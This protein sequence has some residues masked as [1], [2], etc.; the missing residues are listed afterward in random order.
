ME[1]ELTR[2][3]IQGLDI[4]TGRMRVSVI[5]YQVR[6]Y[7]TCHN[8]AISTINIPKSGNFVLRSSLERPNFGTHSINTVALSV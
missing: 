3:I 1:Q 2:M 4:D 7:F 5:T 8:S 6:I